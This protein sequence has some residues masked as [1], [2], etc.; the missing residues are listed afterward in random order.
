MKYC[1][2]CG[3][4]N[5]DAAQFCIACGN[6]FENLA[7]VTSAPKPNPPPPLPTQASPPPLLPVAEPKTTSTN[8]GLVGYSG[9]EVID[10]LIAN[11]KRIAFLAAM[12]IAIS[13][14]F[15]WWGRGEVNFGNHRLI[16]TP[17]GNIILVLGILFGAFIAN[18]KRWSIAF[19]FFPM[20][21]G[22]F[23]AMNNTTV[24]YGR[25]FYLWPWICVIACVIGFIAALQWNPARVFYALL[26]KGDDF[27]QQKKAVFLAIGLSL[28]GVTFFLQWADFF[29]PNFF[30]PDRHLFNIIEVSLGSEYVLITGLVGLRL[31]K[32]GKGHSAVYWLNGIPLALVAIIGVYDFLTIFS[33]GNNLAV[34]ILV[35]GGNLQRERFCS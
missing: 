10:R 19:L 28:Q 9:I 16:G 13:P 3:S 6:K 8:P 32:T 24:D 25:V 15:Y 33:S 21:M 22:T 30:T 5:S 35:L 1:T 12:I 11:G 27:H 20:V 2:Q 23:V 17:E 4:Q 18:G 34:A 29:F 31:F 26:E 14:L 7:P